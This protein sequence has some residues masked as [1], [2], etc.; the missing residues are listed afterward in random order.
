[1]SS[2]SPQTASPLSLR[3]RRCER[4]DISENPEPWQAF[5][6]N[7]LKRAKKGPRRKRAKIHGTGHIEE[8]D[9]LYPGIPGRRNQ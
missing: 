1:L 4:R 3:R 2:P 7:N 8:T 9:S 5:C 6:E